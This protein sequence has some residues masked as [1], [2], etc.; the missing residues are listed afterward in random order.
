MNGLDL[1][2][3]IILL[4]LIIY[5]YQTREYLLAEAEQEAAKACYCVIGEEKKCNKD[6]LCS[7]NNIECN[8]L[9][10]RG[11]SEPIEPGIRKCL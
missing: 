6:C 2:L 5:I 7:G 11:Y 4:I 8:K 9:C 1:L 10:T 3:I